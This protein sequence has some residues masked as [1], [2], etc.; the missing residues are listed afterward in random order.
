MKTFI[1]ATIS[2]I[3][4]NQNVGSALSDFALVMNNNIPDGI[5]SH[6]PRLDHGSKC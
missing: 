4:F 3:I 6:K 1:A 2:N 5:I